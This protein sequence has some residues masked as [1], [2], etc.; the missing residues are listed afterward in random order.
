MAACNRLIMLAVAFLLIL[1]MSER[2][3]AFENDK[4]YHYQFSGSVSVRI[5]SDPKHQSS[6]LSIESP[7][8]VKRSDNDELTVKLEEPKMALFNDELRIQSG[9]KSE[10]KTMD[11]SGSLAKPFKIYLDGQTGSVKSLDTFADEPAWVTNFKRGLLSFFQLKLHGEPAQSSDKGQFFTTLEKSVFGECETEY[12]VL[13]ENSELKTFNVTKSRNMA[14]CK[15]RFMHRFMPVSANECVDNEKDMLQY[16][17]S[18]SVF[19]FGLVGTR[20]KFLIDE[21]KLDETFTYSPFGHKSIT[22]Q[23]DTR[24]ILKLIS[25]E[26]G[27]SLQA[28]SS[29]I[30]TDSL[31]YEPPEAVNF[32]ANVNLEQEHHLANLYES[33]A[34]TDQA[35]TVLDAM[36]KEHKTYL[37]SFEGSNDLPSN[38][39]EN[40]KLA[41]L[42]RRLTEVMGTLNVQKL[43]QVYNRV[44]EQGEAH[45]RVFWDVMSGSGTNPAFVFMKKLITEGDAPAVKIKDFLTRVSFHIKSPSK[46]LFDEYVNL[47]LSDKIQSNREYK[48][49]CLLP[50]ASLIHQH[51]AKPHAKFMRIQSEGGNGTTFK[52]GQNTCQIATADEY[53]TRLVQTFGSSSSS[54]IDELPTG[55]KMF[56]IKMAGELGVKPSID[57]LSGVI[58]NKNEHPTLRA[59][60]MWNLNKAAQIYPS[61]VKRLVV[62]YFYDQ[63]EQIEVRLAALYN[64]IRSGYSLFELETMAKQ[65]EKEPNRQ[66]VLYVHSL[67]KSLSKLD[68]WPCGQSSEKMARLVLPALERALEKH[69][70]AAFGDSHA[71]IA[72]HWL[73]EYGYGDLRLYSAI[74]GDGLAPSNIFLTTGE[75]MVGGIK[76]SPMSISIQTHGLDKVISRVMGKNGLL[77]NKDSF[78]DIFSLKRRSRRQAPSPEL[79]RQEAREMNDVYVVA[80]ISYYGRPISFIDKD[81]KEFKKMLSDDGTIKIPHIKKLLHSFNNHTSQSMMVGFEKLDVFN[82]ELGLPIFQTMN[83]FRFKAFRLNSIK[84]DVEPGFFKDERQ[85]KPPTKISA[86]LDARSV[87]HNEFIGATG[88]NLV[89]SKQQF[90]SGLM[91]KDL[92]NIPIKMSIEANLVTRKVT[93][94]RQPIHDNLYFVKHDPITFIRSYDPSQLIKNEVKPLYNFDN[95]TQMKPFNFEYMTPL[96][97]GLKVAAKHRANLDISLSSIRRRVDSMQMAKFLINYTPSGAPMELRVSTVTTDENPTKEMSSVI[98]WNHHHDSE[99]SAE[100]KELEQFVASRS[101]SSKPKTVHYEL[102]LLGGS[103]KERKVSLNIGYSRSQDRS[104]RKWR[105]FYQRTPL[106]QAGDPSSPYSEATNLCWVGQL[107]MPKSNSEKWNEFDFINLDHT[108]NLTSELTFG[109]QC[110]LDSSKQA[111]GSGQARAAI[112]ARFSWSPKHREMVESVMSGEPIENIG[113]PVKRRLAIL[114][115]RCQEQRKL[116][117]D[118]SKNDKNCLRFFSQAGEMT[119]VKAQIDY[120]EVPARWTRLLS[121]AGSLYTLARSSYIE[122]YEDEPTDARVMD[123]GKAKQ[124]HLEANMTSSPGDRK[125]SYELSGPAYHVVYKGIPFSLPPPSSFRAADSNALNSTYA[126]ILLI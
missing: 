12:L 72:S 36:V 55:E 89:G 14:K 5:A 53:F 50:L 112:N 4:L 27:G 81:S 115:Q 97:I 100:D 26:S 87:K 48:N 92:T 30:R 18:N 7:I 99:P 77:S 88:I 20:E 105:V 109:E 64:W 98:S 104:V 6:G 46:S 126:S 125:L 103:T 83:D 57:F 75:V 121:K 93:I 65:L 122:T 33:S 117:K 2:S 29:A 71:S 13:G 96:A 66:V 40:S 19:N 67:F 56:N 101:E 116:D 3:D 84:F 60:A 63:G 21:A 91:K 94:K 34:T 118:T 59:A 110:N 102:A 123:Q 86:T 8:S 124:A 35:M 38:Y 95:S 68:W 47:C 90:G 10:M 25:T 15:S 31:A 107:D 32:Y 79:A 37:S 45:K 69:A 120:N 51:C 44:E 85:G 24:F 54:S 49:L 76:I 113:C 58:R 22:Q 42:F 43:D 70:P 16:K 74:Y 108:A 80:T 39:M 82:N 78:L 114:Y 9:R 41:S 1:S 111:E 17:R 11:P 73:A 106:N 23:V 28:D 52:K 62:P 61:V 119:H